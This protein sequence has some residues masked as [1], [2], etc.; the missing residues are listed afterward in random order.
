MTEAA[1]LLEE[2][3]ADCSE[4]TAFHTNDVIIQ[5][6]NLMATLRLFQIWCPTYNA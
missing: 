6:V 2:V 5:E 1:V 3:F 4:R